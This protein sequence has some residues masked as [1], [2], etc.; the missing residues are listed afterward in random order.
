MP[1]LVSPLLIPY[2]FISNISFNFNIFYLSFCFTPFDFKVPKF[3]VKITSINSKIMS[4]DGNKIFN[5]MFILCNEIGHH[6]HQLCIFHLH[7]CPIF[8]K[9]DP[10]ITCQIQCIFVICVG[11]HLGSPIP[12]TVH[13]LGNLE[14]HSL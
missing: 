3:Y 5:Y 4:F 10:Q 6:F 9:Q 2:P 13:G 8:V 14:H 7:L 12:T 1:L 11:Y